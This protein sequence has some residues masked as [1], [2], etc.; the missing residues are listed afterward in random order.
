MQNIESGFTKVLRV[1]IGIIVLVFLVSFFTFEHFTQN[2]IATSN[3]NQ[4]EVMSDFYAL[5]LSIA[6]LCLAL[7]YVLYR[8]VLKIKNSLNEDLLSLNTY[9]H[10]I[11]A[12]KD[13]EASLQIEHYL[14][15]LQIS[16]TLKNIIKRLHT[17]DKKK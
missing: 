5:W 16:V 14:E 3:L 4:S 15:F 10:N 7:I 2:L 6:L 9:L 1:F 13:Y 12:N 8:L 11:S 17:K